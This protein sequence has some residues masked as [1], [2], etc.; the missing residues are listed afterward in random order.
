[1]DAI[2]AR[3]ARLCEAT[4]TQEMARFTNK[5]GDVI[6]GQLLHYRAKAGEAVQFTLHTASGAAVLVDVDHTNALNCVIL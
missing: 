3:I 4:I 5:R 2:K 1:M 6:F